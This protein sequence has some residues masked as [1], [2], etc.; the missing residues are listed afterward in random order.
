MMMEVVGMTV[1]ATMAVASS[2]HWAG[3]VLLSWRLGT[4]HEAHDDMILRGLW[5]QSRR[6]GCIRYCDLPYYYFPPDRE[7]SI[8]FRAGRTMRKSG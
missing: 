7:A 1:A 8:K 4:R 3:Q 2:W 6:G 5:E